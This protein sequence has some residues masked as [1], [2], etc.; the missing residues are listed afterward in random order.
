M[1]CNVTIEHDFG[2]EEDSLRELDPLS[3]FRICAQAPLAKESTAVVEFTMS[4]KELKDIVEAASIIMDSDVPDCDDRVL[5]AMTTLIQPWT[6][7][8]GEELNNN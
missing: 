2:V 5:K 4:G 8:N 6:C 7:L 3:R 1:T